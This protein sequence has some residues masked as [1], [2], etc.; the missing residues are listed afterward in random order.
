MAWCGVQE[1]RR[2]RSRRGTQGV[3]ECAGRGGA[4]RSD[5]F[6]FFSYCCFFVIGVGVVGPYAAEKCGI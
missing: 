4:V 6:F 3:S 1:G 2:E 5:F